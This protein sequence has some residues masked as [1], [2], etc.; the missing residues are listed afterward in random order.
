VVCDFQDGH[1][2]VLLVVGADATVVGA[3]ITD[4][5]IVAEHLLGLLE[6]DLAA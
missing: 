6:E 4:P 1:T 3:A 2:A 5:C